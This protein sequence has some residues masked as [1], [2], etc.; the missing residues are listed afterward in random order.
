M[1]LF[2]PPVAIDE[3]L[4]SALVEVDDTG[5]LTQDMVYSSQQVM[6]L[7]AFNKKLADQLRA[8]LTAL[9]TT[10]FKVMIIIKIPPN[11]DCGR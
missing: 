4:D 9:I 11:P 7:I 3:I 6:S 5:N 10:I 8:F 1:S 2:T